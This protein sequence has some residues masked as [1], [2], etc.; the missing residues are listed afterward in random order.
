MYKLSDGDYIIRVEDGACIPMD[1]KNKDYKDYLKWVSK[2][3]TPL[4][5]DP[6]VPVVPQ[7]T[8]DER[9]KSLEIDMGNVKK[10]LNI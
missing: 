2:G 10:L 8:E 6:I 9:I 1:E 4:P 3:N 7:P 5:A